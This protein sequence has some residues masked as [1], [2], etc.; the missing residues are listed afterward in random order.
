[1]VLAIVGVLVLLGGGT[2][3]V[4]ALSKGGKANG[5]VAGS[6]LPTLPTLPS[7]PPTALPSQPSIPDPGSTSDQSMLVKA[8]DCVRITGTAPNLQMLRVA[9]GTA[10]YKVLK[11]FSGTADKTKCRGVPGFTT[12]FYAKNTQESFLSYVICLKHQ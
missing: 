4:L 6:H 11:R 3:A 2:A 10:P 5:P 7:S 1:M 8:G 9:C 12:V